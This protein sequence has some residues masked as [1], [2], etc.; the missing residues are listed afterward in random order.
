MNIARPAS[1]SAAACFAVLLLAVAAQAESYDAPADYYSTATGAGATLKV[2]LHNII[3]GHTNIG[4]DAA[5]TAL[6]VTDAAPGKPGYILTVY[7]RSL[8]NVAAINPNGPV[9]GWDN[10]ATWNRE[11]VWPRS[12]GISSSGPDD[13]DLFNLR[14]A[15]TEGNGDRG[16]LNLGGVYG[17]VF[18]PVA[19]KGS[20][21]WY[22]GD[23]DAGM[24]ARQAFYMA[25]RYDASDSSTTN[26][27]LFAGN[28]S[29]SQGLGD[30]DRMIEWHFAA[31]PDDFER[32]RNQVI[33][34]QYQHNR[35]PFVDR[36][37][38][39]WSVFAN[40]T[41]DSLITLLGAAPADSGATTLDVNLGRII[42]GAAIPA[43]QSVTLNKSGLN[44]TYYQVT[45]SG[46]ATSSIT[47]RYNAFRTGMTGT[48]TLSVGLST[49]TAT[50]GLKSGAVTIDNLDITTGGG[51]GRGARDRDDVVTVN[52][53]VLNHA[54]PSFAA[55]NDINSL[56]Y[57]FGVI[58][59]GAPPPTFT[60][61]IFN[62]GANP[63]LTAGLDLD[64]IAATGDSSVVDLSLTPFSGASTL[65]AAE[66]R[67]F[68][69]SVVTDV[70]GGF[71]AAISL[72]FS[73]EDL[74]GAM[75]LGTMTLTLTG[76]I[77]PAASDDNSDFNADGV[78][79]GADFLVWQ[80]GFGTN[81]AEIGDGDA[82]GDALVDAGDFATWSNQYGIRSVP[83]LKAV[84]EPW[85]F[86]AAGWALPA[87]TLSRRRRRFSR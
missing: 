58:T 41:N 10:A 69:A 28:P 35:N 23:A 14:P 2:Q 82:N 52:L 13:A 57:D 20:T 64:T 80:R 83:A 55:D 29:T 56:T 32:R 19:D 15:L 3:D 79:D 4:Y 44:G 18:G 1:P 53:N 47:G 61:N 5:R 49:S 37:E 76:V 31:P 36:P 46:A 21:K 59:Q 65:P 39:A 68:T 8:L 63:A 38:Y 26:L 74:P 51:S 67:S 9:P 66:G 16:N 62:L 34:D 24:I 54:N 40:Q 33:Y 60:F 72:A 87:G 43:P 22:P 7:D 48:N 85:T 6:Q 77:A 42:V 70:L 71:S 27:E 11:H 75:P 12:R 50:A 25:L 73:D 17:Q 78:V 86:G 30:L 81:D 84:P 45:V